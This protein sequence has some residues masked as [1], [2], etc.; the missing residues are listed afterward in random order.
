MKIIDLPYGLF[1]FQ[2][3]LYLKMQQDSKYKDKT[4]GIFAIE[5]EFAEDKLQTKQL[6]ESD[7]LFQQGDII[8][9]CISFDVLKNNEDKNKPD[10]LYQYSP[11]WEFRDIEEN[12]FFVVYTKEK[13][14][15]HAKWNIG[16]KCLGVRWDSEKHLGSKYCHA[17]DLTVAQFFMHEPYWA[18]WVGQLWGWPSGKVTKVEIKTKTSL[19]NKFLL[20]RK[21]HDFS[22]DFSYMFRL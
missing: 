8:P 6:L 22:R 14:E 2:D 19:W 13:G 4:Y 1:L 20:D 12:E 18:H 11:F 3:K 17:I 10:S 9:A 21:N 5:F 7:K 15:Q 16:E